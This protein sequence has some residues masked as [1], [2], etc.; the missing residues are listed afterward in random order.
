MPLSKSTSDT[1]GMLGQQ[2]VENMAELT[3]A[4]INGLGLSNATYNQ[5]LLHH[6]NSIK[7]LRHADLGRP[8]RALIIAAGPSIKRQEPAAEI[9]RSG[10]DGAVIAT[11]SAML[12]CLRNGIVP[13][14]VVTL[15]PHGDRI[16]RWFGQPD[17]AEHHLHRDDYFARQDLD[18]SF[19]DQLR[20]NE[21]ILDLLS[22]HGKDMR[23]ALSTSSSPQVVQ[24]V[25]DT[26]MDIYW[27][28]PMYDDPDAENSLTRQ[29]FNM[30]G[31]PCINAGGNV[32]SACWMIADAVL[33]KQH[34]GITGMDF[35]YYADTPF[36]NTQYYKEAVELFG[37]ENLESVFIPVF[38][39]FLDQWFYTD[40]A[41]MWYRNCFLEMTAAADCNTYNC[42][43]GGILFGENIEFVPLKEFL[44]RNVN[45]K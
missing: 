5:Q 40:P 20:V 19:A 22:R 18:T 6:G 8:N 14:L 30:N 13:D 10:F 38:N 29:I 36:K 27:W 11:D 28:N 4:R 12:Y 26:G 43:E 7:R 39:P 17:L 15:D 2:L 44:H 32:G 41:Y 1:R 16:V 34:V 23:I 31:L 33:G 37:E 21:E 45:S 3:G 35:G 42:T 25:L 24:R 9:K